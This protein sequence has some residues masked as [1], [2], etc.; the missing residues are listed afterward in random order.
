[1]GSTQERTTLGRPAAWS[2]DMAIVGA[3]TAFLA[4]HAIDNHLRTSMLVAAATSA[5]IGAVLG[6]SFR[7]LLLSGLRLPLVAWVPVGV[8]LGALW[9]GSA[10]LLGAALTRGARQVVIPAAFGAIAGALQLSWFWLSYAVRAGRGKRTWPLVLAA[11]VLGAGVG[12]AALYLLL[13]IWRP[14]ID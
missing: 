13:I 6:T 2:R 10:G 11:A 7:R 14:A 1:M 4:V 12:R 9:G 8:I 3:T 5:M